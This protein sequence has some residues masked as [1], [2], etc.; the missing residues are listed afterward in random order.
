MPEEREGSTV[1]DVV[2]DDMGME[3]WMLVVEEYD[4]LL[5]GMLLDGYELL[6]EE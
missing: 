3:G 6:L 4:E 5:E 1:M 2:V